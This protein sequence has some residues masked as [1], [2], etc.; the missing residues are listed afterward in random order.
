MINQGHTV[1][2][3]V[4]QQ[5][6]SAILS[7]SS[8]S[9][10]APAPAGC[11]AARTVARSTA[12]VV[13]ASSTGIRDSGGEAEGGTGSGGGGC[14]THVAAMLVSR[15]LLWWSDGSSDE[16]GCPSWLEWCAGP[17]GPAMLMRRSDLRRRTARS[18]FR[19]LHR[20]GMSE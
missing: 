11:D 4:K 17:C 20:G 5:A 9:C 16:A 8:A 19:C 6:K 3:L 12:P 10:A 1:T 2:H 13:P 14:V 18:A 7:Q 15:P